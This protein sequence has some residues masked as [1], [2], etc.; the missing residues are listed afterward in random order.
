MIVAHTAGLALLSSL[1]L[2]LGGCSETAEVLSVSANGGEPSATA[3]TASGG[4]SSGGATSGGSSS[5]GT[6][7]GGSSSG[8]AQ[9]E[10]PHLGVFVDAGDSH[11]CATR[12]GLLYCWGENAKGRLG[13]GDEDNRVTPARVGSDADW[14]AVATGVAHTCA[15]KSDGTVWC[16]GD[17]TFGQLGQG[18][19]VA[20]TLPQPVVLPGKVRHLSAEANTACAVLEDGSLYC[21]GRN[22]EG[23]IGLDDEHPGADQPWP[24]RSGSDTDWSVSGTGDGHTCG[25]RGAGLLFCWGRNS[26]A[27]LGLGQTVD[28]QRRVATQVG[29]EQDWSSVVSGQDA[30]CGIRGGGL[31][32]CWGGNSFATLGLGDRDARLSPS[33]LSP[34]GGAAAWSQVSLD[35]FHACGVDTASKLYCWGR[36]LEGQLGT[37]D[38][39][40]RLV[41]GE[42]VAGGDSAQVAQ[43][44]VGR[45]SSCAA[46]TDGRVYCSGENGAGQLG[47]GDSA[48]RN[49]FT[50][51][52]LP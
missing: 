3:G 1:L 16:F 45:F 51:V 25:I 10:D 47:V 37:A 17:N 40:D 27:N 19:L 46:T 24:I 32:F 38:N 2:A 36:N 34:P 22:W 41:P 11:S 7:S 23:N 29:A 43:V 49:T 31:L 5:G 42:V 33:E 52:A 15:L 4:S 30:S 14:I 6:T 20:S 44:A 9:P 21:W 50:Q 48:R 8:G 18:T 12:F 13:L 28:L 35:T 39:D 26:A